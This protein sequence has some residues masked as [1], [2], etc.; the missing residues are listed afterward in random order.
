MTRLSRASRG[1]LR[2]FSLVEL[3]IALAIGAILL[4]A[5]VQIFGTSRQSANASMALARVQES[6][7]FALEL[8][9]PSLRMAGLNTF[10]AGSLQVQNH[11][12]QDCPGFVNFIF[13][14]NA[15][16]LGW[17][18]QGTAPGDSYE[19]DGDALSPVGADPG[20]WVA[21]G[22]GGGDIAL[23]TF[24]VNQVVPGTDV[25]MVRRI[26]PIP[27]IT[28]VGNTPSG[29]SSINITGSHGLPNNSILLVTDCATG[30][31]LFQN[32]S[33]PASSAL[34]RGV[35]ACNNPGPG[36]VNPGGRS[37]S[38]QYGDN[39]QIFTQEIEFYY[40]GMDPATGEPGLFRML[41]GQGITPLNNAALRPQL[42]LPLVDGIEN[43]QIRYGISFAG[44]DPT[45][46]GSGQAVDMWLTADQ[47]NDW[48]L[49]VALRIS[50][51][52]RSQFIA[53][54][55]DVSDTYNL[56]G[57]LVTHAEDRRLRK[58]FT[59][60]IALRNRVIVL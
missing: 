25:L 22:P 12:R 44:D 9:K 36:N 2:G 23:P 30:A 8:I 34:Q 41:L 19:Y 43:M 14:P 59:A 18:F 17:E 3:M 6:G 50:L 10:C 37:W 60:T 4:L 49:V 26:Q 27:G 45:N 15:S 55:I 31:D 16:I 13:D 7:R 51:L 42:V 48:G 58:P 32:S 57:T 39:M 54:Q 56:A 1:R 46:P 21:R 35:G 24:L 5:V 47:V 29:S 52:A 28:A 38:T 40:I 33:A 11:L 20:Q 53:D